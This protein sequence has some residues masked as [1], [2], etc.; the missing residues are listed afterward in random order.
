MMTYK[1]S[2]KNR[3]KRIFVV[4]GTFEHHKLSPKIKWRLSIE[5]QNYANLFAI[6]YRIGHKHSRVRWVKLNPMEY[7]EDIE[8]QKL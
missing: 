7:W 1:I 2:L 4:L 5:V 3:I 6:E 8:V